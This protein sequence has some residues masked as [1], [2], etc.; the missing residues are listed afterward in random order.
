MDGSDPIQR[1]LSL[2]SLP[3]ATRL[4]V[5]SAA[6]HTQHVSAEMS[7]V[8]RG[9]ISNPPDPDDRTDSDS[10][11]MTVVLGQE[12]LGGNFTPAYIAQSVEK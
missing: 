9:V 10:R 3:L 12:T 11:S 5:D 7:P 4:Q 2:L 1:P 8:Y 6:T